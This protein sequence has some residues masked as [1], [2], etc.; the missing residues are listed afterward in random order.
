MPARKWFFFCLNET[1]WF[2]IKKGDKKIGKVWAIG[3]IIVVVEIFHRFWPQLQALLKA[4]EGQPLTCFVKTVWLAK[5]PQRAK[6]QPFWSYPGLSMSWCAYGPERK[7][8]VFGIVIDN[9][10][11]TQAADVIII[12]EYCHW[13]LPSFN[14]ICL[15]VHHAGF[16]KSGSFPHSHQCVE[17]GRSKT[18][19]VDRSKGGL[20]RNSGV[21][22]T[23]G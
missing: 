15:D 7:L 1:H 21:Q 17:T 5:H 20:Y 8:F 14:K 2:K 13:C 12:K 9:R 16:H 3:D 10:Y 6:G 23:N 18:G 11:W 22:L 4:A 19:L